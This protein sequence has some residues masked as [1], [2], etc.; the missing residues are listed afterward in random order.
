MKRSAAVKLLTRIMTL[1]ALVGLAGCDGKDDPIPPQNCTV[2]N[3]TS[4]ITSPATWKSGHVYVVNESLS[5]NA[6]LTIEPNTVVKFGPG[7]SMFVGAEGT[8]M[9][10]GQ[11]AATP[12][13][14]TSIKDDA[15]CGDTNG[16]G[17]ATTPAR[18]DWRGI[19]V[20]S[21]AFTIKYS[22]ITY[23]G[24]SSEHAALDMGGGTGIVTNSI[25]AH[26]RG[27]TITDLRGAALQAGHAETGTLIA[28]NTFY[29]NDVPLAINALVDLDST[30]V[31]HYVAKADTAPIKNKYNGI[32]L[33]SNN[34]VKGH[35]AWSNTE[36]PYVINGEFGIN[37]DASL[38]LAD[39]VVVKFGQNM[40][41]SVTGTLN[42]NAATEIIFTSLKDDAHGGDTNGDGSATAPARGDWRGVALFSSGSTINKCRITYTGSASDWAGLD[43]GGGVNTVTNSV[44]A[45]NSG[46]TPGALTSAALFAGWAGAGTIITGNTF[47]DNDVPLAINAKHNLDNTNVF[48]HV[49]GQGAPAIKNKYN[50][51]F[52]Y[53]Y[54]VES[55]VAWSNTEVPYVI[56][57]EFGIGPDASLT[58][59]DNVILKFGQGR[60]MSLYGTL[61]QGSGNYFTSLKDDDYLG[62]TN[63]DNTAASPAK[64]DWLG[65][66]LCPDVCIGWADWANVLYAERP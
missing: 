64:G 42:A 10:D 35:V 30:N 4:S 62:D 18:G 34:S 29:D 50:G 33:D 51:I 16:D 17:P 23:A 61:S 22:R 48:H 55:P 49:P 54:Y 43:M 31:F 11:S 20:H 56:M 66:H 2:V 46:G 21:S 14:F 25:F 26:N 57:G 47:Y 52:V 13:V 65:I 7:A 60:S 36:V 39:K 19:W 1:V 9:A 5:V 41:M 59:A 53:Y 38:T 8:L 32:F 40:N 63:G 6:A 12:I 3:V 27:G 28:G 44:F 45:H 24:S 37:P 58:L 15:V